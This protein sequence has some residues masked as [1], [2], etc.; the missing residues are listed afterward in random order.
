LHDLNSIRADSYTIFDKIL[1]LGVKDFFYRDKKEEL[2]NYQ[3]FGVYN[4]REDNE[5]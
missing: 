1:D 3:N 4:L 2:E 5:L